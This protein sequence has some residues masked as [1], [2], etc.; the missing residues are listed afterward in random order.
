MRVRFEVGLGL[1]I[2]AGAAIFLAGFSAAGWLARLAGILIGLLVLLPGLLVLV[3]LLQSGPARVVAT[4]PTET[5]VAV[6]DGQHNAFTDLVFWREHFWLAYVSSPSHFM[7]SQSR[8]VLLRSDDARSWQE[9]HRF[10]GAGQDIR[11]PKLGII[12][13][14]LF[15]YA[16]L[17]KTFDPLPYTTIVSHS[18]DGLSWSAFEAV[19]PADWLLGRPVAVGDGVWFAPAHRVDQ[20][21]AVLLRSSDGINWAIHS[22]IFAGDIDRA[23]ESS[24]CLLPNGSLL[25]ASRLES[26]TSILGSEQAATLL[27]LSA[28][29]YT[30]WMRSNKSYATRLDS[31]NLFYHGGRLYALGRSDFSEVVLG[32]APGQKRGSVFGRKRTSLFRVDEDQLELVHLLD[33]SSAGDT[34]YAGVVSQGEQ[35]IISYYSND[36]QRDVPWLLGMLLPSRVQISM[37]ALTSQNT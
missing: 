21:T 24:I 6:D 23:D 4:I 31:P 37:L 3:W 17:N 34:A 20:G 10:D 15:V 18:A 30:S 16:L 26:G 14:E 7:N 12:K 33:L 19:R 28:P 27:S 29:P 35:I 22:T 1:V 2:V 36:P 5:L 9:V 11:D 13:G 32:T 8:V 25:A